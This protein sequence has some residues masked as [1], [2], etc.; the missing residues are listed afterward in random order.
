MKPEEEGLSV[1]LR[2]NE[3]RE[4]VS[5]FCFSFLPFSFF[6]LFFFSGCV[7]KEERKT[8][9]GTGI[10]NVHV[11]EMNDKMNRSIHNTVL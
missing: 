4:N 8:E 10:K 5:V 11:D 9:N 7:W 6:S 1:G 3:K 2:M